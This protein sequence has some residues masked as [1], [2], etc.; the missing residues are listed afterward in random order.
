[1]T[2]KYYSDDQV[3]CPKCGYLM[4]VCG[5]LNSLFVEGKHVVGCD[6]CEHEFE[7]NTLVAYTFISPEMEGK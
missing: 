6:N 1:M 3:R 7:T 4:P 5:D 2:D